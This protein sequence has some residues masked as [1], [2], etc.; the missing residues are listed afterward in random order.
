[1]PLVLGF[2]DVLSKTR[3]S[4]VCRFWYHAHGSPL[5]WVGSRVV[6]NMQRWLRCVAAPP[7]GI[8]KSLRNDRFAG[9]WRR[10]LRHL[11]LK[12]LDLRALCDLRLDLLEGL[13]HLSLTTSAKVSDPLPVESLVAIAQLPKLQAVESH[14][15]GY[16]LHSSSSPSWW[17]ALCQIR[18]LKSFAFWTWGRRADRLGERREATTLIDGLRMLLTSPACGIESL[19]LSDGDHVDDAVLHLVSSPQRAPT[20]RERRR[21]VQRAIRL[22]AT[23]HV[24]RRLRAARN[25]ALRIRCRHRMRRVSINHSYTR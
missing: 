13:T 11:L 2:L 5:A 10:T 1:M 6:L 25:C 20:P 24:R 8:L 18:P 16:T 9:P 21:H 17:R 15:V 14:M 4:R 7:Q 12:R 3:A 19:Q 23:A 22:A